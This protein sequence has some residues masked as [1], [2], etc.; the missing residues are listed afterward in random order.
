MKRI[1]LSIKE[2]LCQSLCAPAKM[3]HRL[4]GSLHRPTHANL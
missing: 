4:V 3:S 1:K 2:R